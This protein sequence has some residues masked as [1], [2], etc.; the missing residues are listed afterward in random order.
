MSDVP[1]STAHL[2]CAPISKIANLTTI[3]ARPQAPRPNAFRERWA[4]LFLN[5]TP[6]PHLQRSAT[7][8]AHVSK[9]KAVTNPSVCELSSGSIAPHRIGTGFH[10]QPWI[11]QALRERVLKYVAGSARIHYRRTLYPKLPVRMYSLQL[12]PRI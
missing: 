5:A 8:N 3:A 12:F 9:E 7:A 2:G 11:G 6:Q 4:P 10:L 1:R